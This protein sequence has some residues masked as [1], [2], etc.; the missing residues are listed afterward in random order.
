MEKERLIQ[1]IQQIMPMS[2]EKAEQITHYFQPKAFLKND[3]LLK[4]GKICTKSY[5][6][7]EG[8]Y[9]FSLWI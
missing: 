5:F 3:F 6:I 8:L 2:L 1:F 9:G 4:E 7:E